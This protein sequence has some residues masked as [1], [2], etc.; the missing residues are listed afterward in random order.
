MTQRKDIN[1]NKVMLYK[2]LPWVPIY[3]KENIR[4]SEKY[5]LAIF[6][7]LVNYKGLR[8]K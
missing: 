5:Y 4:R 7:P 8:K 2:L 6:L 1:K 3:L